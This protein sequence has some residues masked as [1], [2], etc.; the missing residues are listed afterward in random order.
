MERK[1]NKHATDRC[2]RP[3]NVAVGTISSI[4][5]RWKV[6][7]TAVN[8]LQTGDPC[9]ISQHALRIMMRKEEVREKPAVVWKDSQDVLRT[10]SGEVH[11]SGVSSR[12]SRSTPPL[13]KKEA[14]RHTSKSVSTN[15]DSFRRNTF[16]SN[17][18]RIEEWY[19]ASW[20]E[21]HRRT[22]S[23]ARRREHHDMVGGSSINDTEALHVIEGKQCIGTH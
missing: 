16:P 2:K 1:K 14:Q 7:E 5:C 23:E 22:R 11:H 6:Q 18:T 12:T 19:G 17:Q 20:L 21:K 13:Q 8:H 15:Q 4:I 3:L 10:I 9:M